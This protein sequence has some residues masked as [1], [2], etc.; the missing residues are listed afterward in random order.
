MTQNNILILLINIIMQKSWKHHAHNILKKSKKKKRPNQECKR[1]LQSK[2]E[3]KTKDIRY[4]CYNSRGITILDFDLYC[5]EIVIKT[6]WN[7][8]IS[9]IQING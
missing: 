3:T 1:S 9:E 6:T 4:Q 2:T 8:H 7:Q 5:R